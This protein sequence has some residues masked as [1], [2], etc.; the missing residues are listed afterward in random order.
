[1]N[2]KHVYAKTTKT[3]MF[4]GVTCCFRKTNQR[5][6]SKLQVV[7]DVVGMTGGRNIAD[8]Y[9]DFDTD[10]EFKD[11]EVL[12]YGTVAKDMRE[13]FDLF[14]DSET[15]AEIGHL[16]EAPL[17]GDYGEFV[18]GVYYPGVLADY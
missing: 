1:L 18:Y 6:H 17:A 8:R 15:T 10:Y 12:V 11:R 14:W 13:S 3:T 5:M 7:D 9:F 16:R 2:A 4:G